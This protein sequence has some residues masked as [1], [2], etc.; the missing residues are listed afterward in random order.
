MKRSKECMSGLLAFSL[1]ACSI[2]TR[3]SAAFRFSDVW[4]LAKSRYAIGLVGLGLMV[5]SRLTSFSASQTRR[6]MGINYNQNIPNSGNP[7]ISQTIQKSFYLLKIGEI[8]HYLSLK[9]P[10][11]ACISACEIGIFN[12]LRR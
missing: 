12:L 6:A 4:D 7:L 8:I 1:I 9:D 5:A 3:S 10:L 11:W 2:P